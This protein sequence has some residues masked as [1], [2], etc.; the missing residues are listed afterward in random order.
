MKKFILLGSLLASAGT[1]VFA[2]TPNQVLANGQDSAVHKEGVIVR[3]GAI[4][5]LIENVKQLNVQLKGNKE[6]PSLLA[7]IKDTRESIPAHNAIDVFEAFPVEDWFRFEDRSGMI[8]VGVFYLQQFPVKMTE[9]LKV[10]LSKL[11]TT[12][13][14]LLKQEIEKLI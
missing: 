2:K 5:A 12:A 8:M 4:K 1:S 14:P 3:K 11:S 9:E 13:H 10:R 6:T 7:L